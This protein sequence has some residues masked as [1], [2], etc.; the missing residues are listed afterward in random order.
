MIKYKFGQLKREEEFQISCLLEEITD[1][2]GDFYITRDNIRIFI[3]E[4][5]ELFFDSFKKGNRI[6]FNDEYGIAFIDGY[7]DNVKR[8]YLKVLARDEKSANKLIVRINSEVKEELYCKIK[9]KNPL[10]K[11]LKNNG[12]RFKGDRGEE[13]LMVKE[14][15]YVST[16]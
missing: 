1:I 9:K 2:F 14:I 4:N 16:K 5:K 15:K 6:V 13:V 8:K 7:A 10:L 12:F 11:V 3:R